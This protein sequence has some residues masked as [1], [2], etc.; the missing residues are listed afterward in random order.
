MKTIISL[1]N[2]TANFVIGSSSHFQKWYQ[3]IKKANK[4]KYASKSTFT[5][6]WIS[7]NKNRSQNSSTVG[8]SNTSHKKKLHRTTRKQFN[9]SKADFSLNIDETENKVSVSEYEKKKNSDAKRINM[10]HVL[11]LDHTL[12]LWHPWHT[13]Y[14]SQF[15]YEQTKKKPFYW[16]L[17]FLTTHLYYDVIFISMIKKRKT[18][19]FYSLSLLLPYSCWILFQRN[20]YNNNKLFH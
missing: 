7:K 2:L 11:W 6:T 4:K 1:S 3:W 16:T 5:N 10:L 8:L 19:T 17:Q 12:W 15:S 18:T 14:Y 9:C 13:L 20:W